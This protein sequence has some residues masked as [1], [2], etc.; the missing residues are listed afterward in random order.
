[1]NEDIDREARGYD[2]PRV[3]RTASILRA[4]IFVAFIALSAFWV[5]KW[6]M[7]K[8]AYRK[9][10][11]KMGSE[12]ILL[13]GTNVKVF[14]PHTTYKMYT[15]NPQ[16]GAYIARFNADGFRDKDYPREKPPNTARLLIL[17]DSNT[18]GWGLDQ[19]DTFDNRLEIRLNKNSAGRRFEV[20]NL[21]IPG[22]NHCSESKILRAIGITYRPD[23]V[24]VLADS[25]DFLPDNNQIFSG[26]LPELP[27]RLSRLADLKYLDAEKKRYMEIIN[28][29]QDKDS[30]YKSD[31]EVLL[32]E[33][34]ERP[35]QDMVSLRKAEGFRLIIFYFHRLPAWLEAQYTILTYRFDIPMIYLETNNIPTSETAIP[36]DGHPTA[37]A[38]DNYADTAY[39][40][41]SEMDLWKK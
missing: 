31:I 5:I 21:S 18:F 37:S 38:I 39:K 22:I 30:R 25:D 4:L 27:S 36:R 12:M 29:Y 33:F 23:V 24:M 8:M 35:F 14:P 11:I 9:W 28:N 13:K 41:L 20:I 40:E 3:Q 7:D 10:E 1:M 17:G 16:W 6:R 2:R 15:H 26:D 32:K 34:V 19:D